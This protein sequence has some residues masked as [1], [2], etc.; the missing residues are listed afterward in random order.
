MAD[1]D[2]LMRTL[3]GMPTNITSHMERAVR[4]AGVRVMGSVKGKLGRYQTGW[5]KLKPATVKR[6][7]TVKRG[8]SAGSISRAGRRH[9]A[10]H[11]Q[12]AT[13]TDAD[14]PLVDM[15]LYRGSI[16][17]DIRDSGMTA[18][19]G[20]DKIQGPTL[21]FGRDQIPA[22]PHFRPALHENE[23]TIKQEFANALRRAFSGG[24]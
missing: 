24:R 6:K 11:G 8:R 7:F 5:P 15:G 17:M 18:V 14:A 13:G 1:F 3:G 12:W 16:T 21:E 20:T 19:I 2:D 10:E 23:E 4:R 9:L 22:R